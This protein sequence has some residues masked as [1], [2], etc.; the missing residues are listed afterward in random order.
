MRTILNT[1]RVYHPSPWRTNA[2]ASRALFRQGLKA[3][4]RFG[5]VRTLRRSFVPVRDRSAAF[6]RDYPSRGVDR[7]GWMLCGRTGAI[8]PSVLAPGVEMGMARGWATTRE[9]C[10][11]AP[12]HSPASV[13]WCP[14]DGR[15]HWRRTRVRAAT[16]AGRAPGPLSR[17]RDSSRAPSSASRAA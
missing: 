3:G 4:L 7:S 1:C 5:D 10:D 11:L 2:N 15:R 8:A 6:A 12:H 14:S 16:Q 17:T 13:S 9:W